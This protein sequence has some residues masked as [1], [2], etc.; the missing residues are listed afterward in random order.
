MLIVPTEFAGE[1]AVIW[2]LLSMIK[3]AELKPKLTFVAVEKFVPVTITLV[4]PEVRPRFGEI[5]LT[6][7]G[8]IKVN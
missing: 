1:V 6:V 8:A 2:V 7:G 5:P 3:L 4:P